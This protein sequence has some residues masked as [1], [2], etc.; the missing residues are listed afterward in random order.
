[1]KE[2]SG[3]K[4]TRPGVRMTTLDRKPKHSAWGPLGQRRAQSL[5]PSGRRG[6]GPPSLPHLPATPFSQLTSLDP[7]LVGEPCEP[8]TSEKGLSGLVRL[9]E[10][11]GLAGLLELK[12]AVGPRPPGGKQRGEVRDGWG[13]GAAWHG[14]GLRGWRRQGST[15]GR[16]RA[17]SGLSGPDGGTQSRAWDVGWPR[18][19]TRGRG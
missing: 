12:V 4:F 9:V 5:C 14:A 13:R 8:D 11:R 2:K 17:V 7:G 15:Q 10:L 16:G 3:R 19:S 1:M 18:R 6:P